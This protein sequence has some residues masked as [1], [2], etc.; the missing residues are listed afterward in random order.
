MGSMLPPSPNMAGPVPYGT[1]MPPT[2]PPQPQGPQYGKVKKLSGD[3][4][5][6][7]AARYESLIASG[8]TAS[9]EDKRHMAEAD[10]YWLGNHWDDN[11]AEWMPKPS[12][13]WV[14]ATVEQHSANLGTANIVPIILGDTPGDD[15]AADRFDRAI[16]HL[17]KPNK[18]GVGKL[19]RR[20]IHGA[21]LR[22]TDFVKICW[23]PNVNGG[24]Q[25]PPT[26]MMDPMSGQPMLDPMSGQPMMQ[27]TV[28]PMVDPLNGQ[29]YPMTHTLFKGEISIERVDA[30]NIIHDPT[31]YALNGP[32]ACSW[33][34]IRLSRKREWIENNP[35]YRSYV[36]G[37]EKLKEILDNAP[38]AKQG[39]SDVEIYHGR[40]VNLEHEGAEEY[41]HDE[42]WVRRMDE[43]GNWHIDFLEKINDQL[44]N[45]VEDIYKDGEFP[46]GIL[47]DYEIDKSLLGMGEPR[48]VIP[49]QKTINHIQRLIV[50]NAMHMTNSQKIVTTDSGID[51]K[52]VAAF[53]TMPGAVW[54][55]RTPDGIKN[56]DVPDIPVTTFKVAEEAREG[57]RTIMAMDEANMGQFGGSV[58]A[59]S[60]IKMIQDKANVR[61]T[62][63]GMN[64]EDFVSRI[65]TLMISRMQQFYT[66]ERYIPLY[67]MDDRPT[68]EFFPFT[69]SDYQDM[70]FI[71]NVEAG[72]GTPMNKQAIEDRAWKLWE[73]QVQGQFNPPII[74]IEELLDCQQ[75]F[76]LKDRIKKRIRDA[77]QQQ[78]LLQQQMMQQP[79]GAVPPPPGPQL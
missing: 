63:K 10:K 65:A 46:F 60:G 59:A 29:P 53:G 69:G 17:W 67:D 41:L 55:S 75:G 13:N 48:Q 26:P 37:K 40:S 45:Y 62:A 32:G 23:D 30:S 21:M 36:G 71:V 66:T 73:S 34:A 79:G 68:G 39:K 44:I 15:D 27:P 2:A 58:T 77:V 3:K 56:L 11:D 52:Q 51:D 64:V 42:V 7:V 31:G 35:Q 1:P 8:I 9:R 24:R 72:A 25:F 6:E 20:S 76:P 19:I 22:G 16:R 38:K 28:M 5:K 43:N 78:A 12:E 50:L 4:A 18:L 57:I 70:S 54:K 14:F 74:T 33:I 49:N 47:Y 61:D